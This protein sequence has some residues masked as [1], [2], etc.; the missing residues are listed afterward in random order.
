MIQTQIYKVYIINIYKKYLEKY[1]HYMKYCHW[2]GWRNIPCQQWYNNGKKVS[3]KHL[4]NI[5]KQTIPTLPMLDG[6]RQSEQYYSNIIL[7]SN[8]YT[9]I[10]TNLEICFFLQNC[11]WYESAINNF[12][13]NWYYVGHFY[14]AYLTRRLFIK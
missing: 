5:S 3:P 14:F 12:L 8:K 13:F 11:N 7:I 9:G 2:S 1:C 10:N 4:G 6:Y